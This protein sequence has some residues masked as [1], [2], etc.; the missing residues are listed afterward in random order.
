LIE[1]SLKSANTCTLDRN[2]GRAFAHYLLVLKLNDTLKQSLKTDFTYVMREWTEELERQDRI[3]DLFKCYEQACEVFPECETALNN[4]GAQLFRLGYI[5]EGALYI[6]KALRI[7]PEYVAARQ[8]LEN[9]CSFLVDRWHFRMLNDTIR[10]EAYRRVIKDVVSEGNSSILDIGAGTGLLSIYCVEAGYKNIYACERSKTMHD[11]AQDVLKFNGVDQYIKLLCKN[12]TDLKIPSD[13]PEKCLCH[14]EYS[15]FSNGP[16]V[17]IMLLIRNT[18]NKVDVI[19]TETF[20]AGLFGEHILSTLD[21]AIKQL[22]TS[23]KVG[24][25]LILPCVIPASASVYICA[26]ESEAILNK[27]RFL[28]SLPRFLYPVVQNVDLHGISINCKTTMVDDEPYTTEDLSSIRGGYIEL[29]APVCLLSVE[30]CNSSQIE[31]LLNGISLRKSLKVTK[32]GRLDAIVLWFDLHLGKDV[33]ITTKPD[34]ANC[35]EQALYPVSIHKDIV[36]NFFSLI[37]IQYQLHN[38]HLDVQEGGEIVLDCQ[39]QNSQ[40]KIKCCEIDK[41]FISKK[42]CESTDSYLFEHS[43]IQML[44]DISSNRIFFQ[45]LER[46]RL[47]RNLK[48]LSLLDICQGLSPLGLQSAILGYSD[49]CV[50]CEEDKKECLRRLCEVNDMKDKVMIMNQEELRCSEEGYDVITCDLVESCGVF[51]QQILEEI[52]LLR[53]T[54]LREHGI[55]LPERVKIYG[56]CIESSDLVKVSR[57]ISDQQTSGYHIAQ[58]INDFQSTSHVEIDLHTLKHT[59]LS[60]AFLLFDFSLNLDQETNQPA[61]FLE[62]T[63]SV[64]VNIIESGTFTAIVYWFEFVVLDEL[65]ISSLDYTSHWKQAAI[66]AKSEVNVNE[67]ENLNL[68]FNLENSCVEL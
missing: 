23:N 5:D 22:V 68:I 67:G 44:N 34:T 9:I 7:A 28:V 51:K 21:H 47:A 41:D 65:K 25:L 19:V 36:K 43:E 10:N 37:L 63:S 20:D 24:T 38:I 49:V 62:Q 61:S 40:L 53:V 12:S 17:H 30:F 64:S 59:K 27:N 8:N 54:S 31:K 39:L 4:I 58:F 52:A 50:C 57:V 33:T 29:S 48:N 18:I 2:Y 32:T 15:I 6:R 56:I 3:E 13:I 35:W 60:S 46:L 11:V 14:S 55:I 16:F 66:M 45:A 42:D 1:S 26:I